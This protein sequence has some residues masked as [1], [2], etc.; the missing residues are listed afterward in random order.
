MHIQA[1]VQRSSQL[2]LT[3]AHE[4]QQDVAATKAEAAD[5]MLKLHDAEVG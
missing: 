2:L 1:S 3:R 4:Q 5:L